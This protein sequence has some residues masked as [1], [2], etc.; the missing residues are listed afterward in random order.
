MRVPYAVRYQ[1]DARLPAGDSKVIQRGKA[2]RVVETLR[3]RYVNGKLEHTQVMARRTTTQ[4]RPEIRLRGT[5]EAEASSTWQW[6]ISSHVVTSGFG[7]RVLGGQHEFHP[8]IDL[9]CSVGTPVYA[10]NNGRVAEA[11]PN[12]GGY[13]IWVVLDHG[14]GLQSVY[15]HL[16]RVVVHV[17]QMVHK[18]QLIAYS[19]ATGRVTGPHLHYEVRVD[20]RPVNPRPYM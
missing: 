3:L 9:A 8:G 6:P 2:G 7:D 20:G 15:G 18:G 5:N 16:S 12:N 17:G 11:G 1:D 4:S 19:G 10:A 13:G 14:G